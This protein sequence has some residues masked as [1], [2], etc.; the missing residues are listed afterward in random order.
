MTIDLSRYGLQDASKTAELEPLGSA[1]IFKGG[2]A[3]IYAPS[4]YGKSWST[5]SLLGQRSPDHKHLFIDSDGSNGMEFVRHCEANG[6]SYINLDRAIEL[7]LKKAPGGL[8]LETIDWC[9]DIIEETADEVDCFIIDSF[10]SVNGGGEINNAEKVAPILYR[11]NAIADKRECA[12]VLIDHAT[13]GR[14]NKSSDYKIE[15][16]ESGKRKACSSVLK[17]VPND[18]TRADLGGVFIVEKSRDYSAFK[19]GDRFVIEPAKDGQ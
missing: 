10:G 4:G 16:N 2:L 11:L 1:P 15:G 5:A 7:K 18:T 19:T 13:K 6:V 8:T 17:Y 12:I 9:I 14:S 3:L